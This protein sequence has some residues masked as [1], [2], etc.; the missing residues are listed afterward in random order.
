MEKLH[1][2]LQKGTLGQTVVA[3][4]V[5]AA[6]SVKMVVLQRCGAETAATDYKVFA[7]KYLNMCFTLLPAFCVF[8]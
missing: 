6:D 4:V 2:A 1:F 7:S 3:A 8:E 5:E